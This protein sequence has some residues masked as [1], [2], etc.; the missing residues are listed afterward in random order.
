MADPLT[1]IVLV[2]SGGAADT[3]TRAMARATR[4]A[5][6]PEVHVEVREVKGVPVDE[7]ALAD[8]R[9]AHADA[10]VELPLSDPA[11]PRGTVRRHAARRP[12]TVSRPDALRPA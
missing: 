8:E 2:A 5:L 11:R 4:D 10:V 6:G 1:L 9:R 7:E 12:R 3:T